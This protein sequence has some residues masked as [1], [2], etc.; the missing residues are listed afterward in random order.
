RVAPDAL[1]PGQDRHRLFRATPLEVSRASLAARGCVQEFSP[2]GKLPTVYD[3][4]RLAPLPVNRL[5]GRMT[6][7]GDVTELLRGGDDRF[8][9]FGPGDERDVRFDASKLPPLPDGWTRSYVLR[10]WGYCKDT[11]PFTAHGD[12]VEPLPFRAMSNYPCGPGEKYP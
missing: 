9:I 10:T 1:R 8:L 2:D 12:T 6:R 7:H 11:G 5:A 3:Y 4:G